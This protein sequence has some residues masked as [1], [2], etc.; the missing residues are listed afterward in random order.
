[1]IVYCER[2]YKW[3]LGEY[4][5]T[6]LH[7]MNKEMETINGRLN[8]KNNVL[9][10]N[11][12]KGKATV[13][14][15]DG[16]VRIYEGKKAGIKDSLAKSI[17]DL[18]RSVVCYLLQEEI[19]P[20]GQ[21]TSYYYH[22]Y[23]EGKPKRIEITKTNPSRTKEYASL[24]IRKSESKSPFSVEV[25]SS[26][27]RRIT[28]EWH[29]FKDQDYLA[30]VSNGTTVLDEISYI[31]TRR[32]QGA[33]INQINSWGEEELQVEYYR[34][35]SEHKELKWKK[36]PDEK[37]YEIDKVKSIS[38]CGVMLAT[39]SY[40]L[41]T[42]DVRDG[43]DILTR[44][45]HRDGLLQ[46]IEYFDETQELYSSQKFIWNKHNLIAK[47]MKDGNGDAIFS[48]T[49][50]CDD[51]GNILTESLYGNFSGKNPGPF[52]ATETGV[53]IG[54]EKHTREYCYDPS[55]HL[56]IKEAEHN[57]LVH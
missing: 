4:I 37:S 44:Y 15:A 41:D 21:R 33:S 14:C 23:S 53:L 8:P 26:D 36:Y 54:A 27:S 25:L 38:K 20:S 30:S 18:K 52:Q 13:R 57:G 12:K 50:D 3:D 40:T 32:G 45:H 16:G 7:T 39:F 2:D 48:K 42:T 35:N 10:I 6:P 51:Y 46:E 5:L 56:I 55:S 1:M 19:S 28:Y 17:P 47:V 29:S 43:D 31:K 49:L 9:T 22:D 24:S 34:P 11:Y